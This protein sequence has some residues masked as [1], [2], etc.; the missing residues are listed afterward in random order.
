[1]AEFAKLFLFSL[2]SSIGVIIAYMAI[3][4]KYQI[5]DIPNNRSSHQSVVVRGAGVVFPLVVITWC[6]FANQSLLFVLAMCLLALVSFTDDVRSVPAGIRLSFHFL[7]MWLI[8]LTVGLTRFDVF[9]LAACLIVATGILSAFNF[10]D[11]INGITGVYG[12]SV[13]L[14]FFFTDYNLPYQLMVI[15]AGAII[16][17]L[18]FNFR[19]RALCFAGDVGSV[20][21]SGFLIFLLSQIIVSTNDFRWISFIS[22]YGIDSVTTI[23]LRLLRKENIFKPHRTHLYQF[24]ANEHKMP[25]LWISF[26][27]GVAQ[28]MFNGIYLLYL[29][30]KGLM[31]WSLFLALQV[32]LYAILR[33]K[34]TPQVSKR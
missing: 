5:V 8:F 2:L 13:L 30:P 12:F 26:A 23:F 22:I 20:C 24:L 1:M 29:Q 7:S 27:Y 4:R 21:I 9:I 10:M 14:S 19:K 31:F 16:A 28:L 3:A 34:F 15:M 33:Y 32:V 25:H 18:I 11:G 17:F 6:L